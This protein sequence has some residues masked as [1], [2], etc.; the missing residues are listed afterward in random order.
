[1]DDSFT[2]LSNKK[3][4]KKLNK[5]ED[6]FVSFSNK[7]YKVKKP[8]CREIFSINIEKGF[9]EFD[10]Y[11]YVDKKI[12]P[13]KMYMDIRDYNENSIRYL[14]ILYKKKEL[15]DT[16]KSFYDEDAGGN[17][18]LSPTNRIKLWFKIIKVIS[19]RKNGMDGFF[20]KKKNI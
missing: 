13:E 12:L 1:M 6:L 5:Y 18:C 19:W 9:L 10:G 4:I 11:Y 2:Y 3:I 14:V 20:R 15:E 17:I 8:C 7:N 16:S